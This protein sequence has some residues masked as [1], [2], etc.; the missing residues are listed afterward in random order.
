[1]LC[2][3]RQAVSCALARDDSGFT[4][5]FKKPVCGVIFLKRIIKKNTS[6]DQKKVTDDFDVDVRCSAFSKT[7]AHTASV[8][9]PSSSSVCM[10]VDY[11]PLTA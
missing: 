3:A 11:F 4:G 10:C 9:A 7:T 8:L 1:M 2:E 6:G 5:R